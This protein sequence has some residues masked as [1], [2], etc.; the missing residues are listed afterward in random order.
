MVA[1]N[2][3]KKRFVAKKR[4]I[5]MRIDSKAGE[6]VISIRPTAAIGT[7]APSVSRV[8][9]LAVCCSLSSNA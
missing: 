4:S 9:L 2:D 7:M 1:L 3:G 5:S 8:R 6:A